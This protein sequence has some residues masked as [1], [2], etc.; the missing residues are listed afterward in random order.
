MT[1][2]CIGAPLLPRCRDARGAG[3]AR[4]PAAPRTQPG[5]GALHRPGGG[6]VVPVF[7]RVPACPAACPGGPGGGPCLSRRVSRPVCE[8]GRSTSEAKPSTPEALA[9]AFRC[10]SGLS[11]GVGRPIHA[12]LA[13]VSATGPGMPR[14]GGVYAQG[15]RGAKFSG[16]RV[17]HSCSR[18][19]R[20]MGRRAGA[21]VGR[22]CG[23]DGWAAGV[24]ASASGGVRACR[25]HRPGRRGRWRGWRGARPGA[26]PGRR[27]G[28]RTPAAH[29]T[30]APAPRRP[31]GFPF[32]ARILQGPPLETAKAAETRPYG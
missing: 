12:L 22:A 13:R 5:L 14:I 23:E 24:V 16:S 32:R 26:A 25:A 17:P 21:P 2:D 20:G 11:G 7:G 19:P 29:A 10:D 6:G 15:W 30:I 4:H 8:G 9:W 3:S 18:A 28:R 27:H 31:G 1:A